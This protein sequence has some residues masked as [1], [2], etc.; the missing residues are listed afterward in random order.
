MAW[1]TPTVTHTRGRTVRHTYITVAGT[2]NGTTAITLDLE[3]YGVRALGCMG[4][5]VQAKSV[6]GTG[7][8]TTTLAL[9]IGADTT[10]VTATE[11]AIY[12]TALT[13]ATDPDYWPIQP[14]FSALTVTGFT[15]GG[16]ALPLNELRLYAVSSNAAQTTEVVTVYI[17]MVCQILEV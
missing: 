1:G 11:H 7:T 5:S 8:D 4:G 9:I 13:L 17:G 14:L 10:A 12:N 2:L 16:V 6:G 15:G 3:D